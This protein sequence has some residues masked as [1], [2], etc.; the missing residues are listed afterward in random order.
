M[1]KSCAK[2]KDTGK[3]LIPAYLYHLL[4]EDQQVKDRMSRLE[5]WVQDIFDEKALGQ[6]EALERLAAIYYKKEA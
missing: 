6:N 1:A 4:P 2:A 5:R 3:R